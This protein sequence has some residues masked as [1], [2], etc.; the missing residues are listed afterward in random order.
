[1]EQ[2]QKC[3]IQVHFSDGISVLLTV[4]DKDDVNRPGFEHESRRGLSARRLSRPPQIPNSVRH[5][6][7]TGLLRYRSNLDQGCFH[8]LCRSATELV[9]MDSE[10]GRRDMKTYISAMYGMAISF[11]VPDPLVY[12]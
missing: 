2:R 9:D 4:E 8:V 10:D 7:L 5:G 11:F 6:G 3:E 1:M 12:R